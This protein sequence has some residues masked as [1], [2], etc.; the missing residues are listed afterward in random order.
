MNCKC[1]VCGQEPSWDEVLQMRPDIPD[2]VDMN[3]EICLTEIEQMLYH[4][5]LCVGCVPAAVEMNYGLESEE[6]DQAA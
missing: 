5:T 3:G 1:V 2:R 6:V 4:Q